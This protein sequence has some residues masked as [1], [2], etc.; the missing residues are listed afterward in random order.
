MSHRLDALEQHATTLG[1]TVE[2]R[3]LTGHGLFGYYMKATN[4]IVINN[5]APPAKDPYRNS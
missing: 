1:V 5:A 2:Y 4:L 3:P